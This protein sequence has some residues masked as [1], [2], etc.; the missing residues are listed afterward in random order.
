MFSDCKKLKFIDISSFRITTNID[1]IYFLDLFGNNISIN[2]NIKI[3]KEFY[4]RIKNDSIEKWNI[5]FV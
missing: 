1:S 4:N 3:N 5:S 2:G